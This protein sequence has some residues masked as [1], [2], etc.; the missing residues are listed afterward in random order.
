MVTATTASPHPYQPG[1]R[2]V[3]S[4]CVNS[5]FGGDWPWWLAW[6]PVRA[7]FATQWVWK[8]LTGKD[9]GPQRYIVLAAK[10]TNLWLT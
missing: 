9:F 6:L 3:V 8:R 7:L 10:E 4:G 2:I 1:D 5:A